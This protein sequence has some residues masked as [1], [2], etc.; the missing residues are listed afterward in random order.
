MV[1]QSA[2]QTVAQRNLPE[3]LR[4]EFTA[5]YSEGRQNSVLHAMRAGLMAL[6]LGRADLAKETFDQAI[7]EV[8]A[9]QEG[10]EQAQRAKSKFVGEREKWFKGE[11]YERAALYFYRGILFLGDHDYGNAAAC[12]KRAQLQDIT[13]EEESGFAGDWTSCELG[14]ALASTWN[15]V[16]SDAT[17]ARQ[18]A[19]KFQSKQGEVPWPT[20]QTNTLLVV[21]VGKAP[22]KYRGGNQGEQLRYLEE[23]PQIQQIRVSTPTFKVTSAPAENLF[24]QATTRGDRQVDFFLRDKASFKEDTSN[25]TVGLA[26]AAVVAS[27][28]ERSGIA[29]GVLGLAAIGTAIASAVSD[30]SADIRAWDNLPHSIYLLN[31]NLPNPDMPLQ[32][33]ALDQAGNVVNTMTVNDVKI[34]TPTDVKKLNVLFLRI[35]TP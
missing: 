34:T 1:L 4:P 29:A 6:R 24:F 31:L 11:S 8:E 13:S 9:L 32:I 2:E 26:A 27:Q 3:E 33:E 7:R 17:A 25:A 14:L 20:P 5:L 22:V 15:G 12:F 19:D 10:T 35:K 30:P 18:R 21:E 16:P 23:A 28:S